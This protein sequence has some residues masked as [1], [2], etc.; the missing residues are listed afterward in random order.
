MKRWEFSE[1]QAPRALRPADTHT[2]VGVVCRQL[3]VS[4]AMFYARETKDAHLGVSD[5]DAPAVVAS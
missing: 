5:R 4:E 1:G 3:E 2:P